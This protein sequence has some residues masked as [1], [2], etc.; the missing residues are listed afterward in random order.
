MLDFLRILRGA[1]GNGVASKRF[2]GAKEQ[3]FDN[4]KD[5]A[6]LEFMRGGSETA[7][8]A[9]VSASTALRNMTVLR[10]ISLISRSIGMLPLNLFERGPDLKKAVDHPVYRL[11]RRRPNNWQTPFKFKTQMQLNAL[12]HG[13]AY[14]LAV[15]SR[16]QVIRLVPLDPS[17]VEVKQNY[18]WTLEYR[19][20]RPDGTVVSVSPRDMFHISDMSADGVNGLSRVK[21]AREAIGLAMR[22]EEAAARLFKNGM[23]VGG[24]LKHPHTLSDPALQRLRESLEAKY[25]GA[26]NAHKWMILEEGMD[27]SPFPQTA[28]N[29]QQV[30]NRKLQIEEVARAFDVPRPLLMMDDTSWGSGIEQLGIFFVQYALAPWFTAWEEEIWRVLLSDEE[31]NNDSY[32][33]KFNERALLRGTLKDQAEFFAKALG[34]GGSNPWMK[35]NEVREYSELPP[36]D[37]PNA[38]SLRNQMT[39]GKT[40]N[41]SAQITGN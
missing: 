35:Q 17:R 13:D 36:S 27:A 41:E 2:F 37:D 33:A 22:I 25:S 1:G 40:S 21:M 9:Y 7:S 14:A 3:T 11:L 5:P 19:Y 34:S 38:E 29:S 32:Y 18:D 16:G 28:Q 12:T 4:L 39:Q 6:L 24:T 10:C 20:S 26:E 31:Q 23:M 8:G 15:R 30:E